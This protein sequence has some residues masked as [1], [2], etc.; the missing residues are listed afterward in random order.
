MRI[1]IV[2]HAPRGSRNG[3]RIT[4]LR[5][6][7]LLRGLKQQVKI[8]PAL[9]EGPI[10]V[11][12]ALHA[13]HSHAAIVECARRWPAAKT[14]VTMTG[15]D[16]YVD[17]RGNDEKA[18][19]VQDS[20]ARAD[21][22]LG[23]HG[24]VSGALPAALREKV[25]IVLQ[26][27]KPPRDRPPVREDVFEAVLVGHLRPVKNPTLAIIAASL[28]PSD[29][30]IELIQIG[31]SLDDELADLARAATAKDP[32]YRWIG[33]MNRKDT[34]GKIAA[35]RALV[36]TSHSEGGSN[37]LTEAVVCGTPVISTRIAAA[38]DLLGADYPGLFAPDDA[39]GL[40]Q[41]LL[42]AE[43]NPP[44]LADLTARCSRAAQQFAPE[45]ER[46]AWRVLISDLSR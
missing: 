23:L 18:A 13:F 19:T 46:E 39:C 6:A 17:L 28:L 21:L 34:L 24:G 40:A 33:P 22:I 4:A 37:V 8:G 9:P 20:F 31:A 15:T 45:R 5:W 3:N 43:R 41:I 38:E 25:R 29:S 42:R 32:R 10:D 27:A 2:T 44:F 1:A 14:L 16:L 7:G 36:I 26:S 35:A 12:I 30:R 11:L